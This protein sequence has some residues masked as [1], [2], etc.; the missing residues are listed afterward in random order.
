M[1]SAGITSGRIT[2]NRRV[3]CNVHALIAV[4]ASLIIES[5]FSCGSVVT[6]LV[7]KALVKGNVVCS[8]GVASVSSSALVGLQ[9]GI[10]NSTSTGRWSSGIFNANGLLLKAC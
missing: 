9:S 4:G 3:A 6:A 1:P 10:A 8:C 2:T 7:G 5:T